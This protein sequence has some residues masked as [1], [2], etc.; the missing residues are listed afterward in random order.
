MQATLPPYDRLEYRMTISSQ[1]R[2]RQSDQPTSAGRQEITPRRRRKRR[3]DL[4][5]NQNAFFQSNNSRAN[6]YT[7]EQAAKDSEA[8]GDDYPPSPGKNC[9]LITFQNIG[10]Q[11]DTFFDH[12]SDKTSK[13][14]KESQA[15]IALYAEISLVESKLEAADRF[16]T[17]MKRDSPHSFSNV[18]SNIHE[19]EATIWNQAGGAAFTLQNNIKAHQTTYGEDTTGLGRWTW[20][21]LRGKATTFT[22]IISA[23]R[24]CKNGTGL[25]TVWSQHCRYFRESDSIK[26]PNPIDEFD[27][28]LIHEVE[29][30]KLRGD[31]IIIGID[32]NADVRKNNLTTQL[33][34]LHLRDAILTA[35]PTKSPP[36][37][38][39]RNRSRI[40]IDSMWVSPNLEITRAGYMPFDGG[41]PAAPSDGHRMLWLEVDNFSFLGKHI[42]TSTPPLAVS[43]VKSHDP[44]SR[45]RYQRLV[46]K[47]YK[48]HRVFKITENLAKAQA[49]FLTNDPTAY[50]KGVP[51]VAADGVSVEW[52]GVHPDFVI[53]R[54]TLFTIPEEEIAEGATYQQKRKLHHAILDKAENSIHNIS[55]NIRKGVDKKMRQIYAG[56]TAYSPDNQGLRDT[57]TFWSRM[58]KLKKKVNTSRTTLKRLAKKLKLPWLANSNTSLQTA[59]EKLTEAYTEMKKG[60]PLA[61]KKRLKFLR[62][63]IKNLKDQKTTR[64]TLIPSQIKSLL[65]QHRAPKEYRKTLIDALAKEQ[66]ILRKTPDKAKIRKQIEARIKREQKSRNIGKAARHIR[67]KGLKDPVLRA[68]ANDQQGNPYDCNSQETMVRAMAKSNSERQQQC[69]QTPFQM[70]PL[71]DVFG[72]LMDNDEAG[73][74]VMDGTFIPPAGTD[75][76]AVELLET[77]KMEDS[78]R[79]L[80]PLDMTIT[81][82]DNRAGW[83]K[84]TERTSSEPMGLGFN[85]YKAACLTDDL[86][87]VDT[88][89]RN[90][91]L[92]M[93]TSPKLWKLITDFQI[94]KRSN[95]FHVDSMRLIQLMDAEYNMNNKTLG[96]RVLAHAEKAKAVSPDQYGCRKN[97]TAINACLNKVLLMDGMRQKKQAGA[98]AM[99]DAKGCF[100]RI[101]HT[102]A[103]LVLMSFGVSSLLARSVFETLQTADHHIKTGYG[104]SGKAY[105]NNDEEEPHQGIGQGNGL[106][107]TLWALLS[108]ILIKNM[109]RHGHGVNLRS[110]LSLSLVSIVCFAFVDDTDLAITGKDRLTTGEEVIEEF[111]P[112]LDRWARSLIVSGGALCSEKSFCYLIDFQWTGTDWEY[113]SKDDMPGSFTLIDKHGTRRELKRMNAEEAEKT[114]GVYLAMDGNDGRQFRHLHEEA[115][116]F[117][118]QIRS[119]KCDN[120]TAFYTY[121]NCF[122]KSMEYCMPTTDFTETQWNDILRPA[123]RKALQRSGIAANFPREVLYSPDLYQGLNI[124]NPRFCEGIKKISTLIQESVNQ[125]STGD[126]I[127]LTAEGLRLELGI[128]LI[129]GRIDWNIVQ[130]YTTK[131]WYRGVLNFASEHNIEF[132]EDYPQIPLLRQNDQY[133]M[134]GFIKAGYRNKELQILNYMRMSLRAIS[135]A[136]ITSVSGLTINHLAW[137][138][139]EGNLLREHYD[140]PRDPPSFT[141]KQKDFWKKALGNTFIRPQSIL[142]HRILAQPVSTWQSLSALD[143]W[144]YFYN[145]GED[146]L[147][148]KH[149]NSW[150]IYSHH[151]GR[152]RNR[153]YSFNNQT[154]ESLP[155]STNLL[156]SVSLRHTPANNPNPV[157]LAKEC[158]AEWHYEEPDTD[159][160]SYDPTEGPFACI[161]DAFDSSRASEKILLD[162]VELPADDCQAIATGISQGTA[163]AISDGSYD[164]NTLKGTSALII[165]ADKDD[166]QPLEAANW[167]PGLAFDQSAYRSELAGVAGILAAVAIIVQ[168]YELTTGSITIA[169]DGESALDVSAAATI[170]KIGQ[171]DF[172]LV[173]EI[174]TRIS[175]LPIT[176]N[177][178]WV[179]G[180]QDRKG[181]SMDWWARKNTIVDGKAKSYLKQCKREKRVH[182]PVRLLY[183]KWAVYVNGIKIS[184]IDTEPLYA[185][186]FA[187]RSLEYWKKHHDIKVDPQHDTDWEASQQ[188]IKKLPQGQKRWLSKQA[189]GCIGVGHVLKIRKWQNHSRCP[190]CNKDEEKTSHVLTCQDKD[191]KANFKKNLDT[192]L[193][194]TLD[195]TNTAPSLSKAILEILQIWRQDKKVNPSD[196]TLNFGIRAAI[197]DQNNG[198][199]WTN[200]ALGR[201]SRKW[202]V[203]QQQFYDR[204]RSKKKSK[205]WAA[206][207]IHKLL[208]TAW[209]QWDFRNKI[210][211]SD[212]GPGAIA[213][214]QRLDAEMLEETRSDNRQI[215]RQDTFLFTKWTYT[216]LQALPSQQKQQWLRSVF[217]AR[218]AINYNAPTVPYISAMSVAMQ[219]Y[220]D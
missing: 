59:K 54:T 23:Y 132:I 79:A 203:S 188:A 128:P 53:P 207:I 80:G 91:P 39:N 25:S 194:P 183:E 115:V 213:L 89:F 120:N 8:F 58:V 107:P 199:G 135:V 129:A 83:K 220:L 84:Q 200:F 187:P 72:Y 116:K 86:N 1:Q 214:R 179:E 160:A 68:V 36:A 114:L 147:F 205:R 9:T 151:S 113:R 6:P 173:Q 155:T 96:K 146:R 215:L 103:I 195:S 7:E 42:P 156:A 127:R 69:V 87:K 191:S 118:D 17:R 73:Q 159:L 154:C 172:D 105:G 43:R 137:E 66:E 141:K 143:D 65:K 192:I 85:H 150:K 144:P 149:G 101:N 31:N 177:W 190:L 49:F 44:R 35:H 145:P 34:Q 165:V 5:E 153:K 60:K 201:W 189:S 64:K 180:H 28:D 27:R 102:F 164:P 18:T 167:V 13:A 208:L 22:T 119:S 88:F 148:K 19:K 216:E 170:M 175:I 162:K 70:A 176:V 3:Q 76:V 218:K 16:S 169:L 110:A 126:L 47:A 212:E 90:F 163:R 12:K 33:Q 62:E 77:L 30:L 171:A 93:G 82:E 46:R 104:R 108:S 67:R 51:F 161:Q 92:Q 21:R 57:V 48:K 209:D 206:A 186:L 158:T 184:K 55:R 2:Q 157:V 125:S 11:K 181:K 202:Q 117:G 41:L 61:D 142:E 197:K 131:V 56:A 32:M 138:L 109:K 210:A 121:T 99:N 37:T 152:V 198:L 78:I 196:F 45:R 168:H 178:K 124:Y 112:A 98:I 185:T 122:L 136:D 95:V 63:Q 193:K 100:D 134:Q 74:Q 217:Q 94:F 15:G 50:D 106:G 26:L 71:L 130:A 211:H 123:L 97:H 219:N 75:S 20:T 174:R 133:I 14:F 52:S 204:I 111:Q 29:K 81:P 139:R 24:P 4:N 182:R 10:P 140:W 166:K 40:P 38:F